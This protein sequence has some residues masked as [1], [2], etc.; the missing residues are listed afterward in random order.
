MLGTQKS[1]T[2]LVKCTMT[3]E[4]L[5]KTAPSDGMVPQGNAAEDSVAMFHLGRMYYDGT[6]LEKDYTK[7]MEWCLKSSKT[8]NP[9][10]QALVGKMYPDGRNVEQ[11]FTKLRASDD[12]NPFAKANIGVIYR[13]A[14]ELGKTTSKRW[15]GFSKQM[16]LDI[17]VPRSL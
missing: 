3:A 13:D 12:G 5:S 11:D 1:C 15:N 14:S 2:T 9:S 8:E 16:T 7:E 17:E 6:G 4:E 10:A